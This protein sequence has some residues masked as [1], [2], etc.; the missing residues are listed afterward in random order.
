[1]LE[2]PNVSFSPVTLGGTVNTFDVLVP[3]HLPLDS[4]V[5]LEKKLPY[6]YKCIELHDRGAF[7]EDIRHGFEQLR[8]ATPALLRSTFDFSLHG[9]PDD[10]T[11]IFFTKI[12]VTNVPLRLLRKRVDIEAV[13]AASLLDEISSE[14]DTAILFSDY[15][16][17]FEDHF[18]SVFSDETAERARAAEKARKFLTEAGKKFRYARDPEEFASNLACANRFEARNVSTQFFITSLEALPRLLAS[19]KRAC[20]KGYR[21]RTFD[22]GGGS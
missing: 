11:S 15:G 22:A 19:L 1:L 7:D 20:L 18:R 17:D 2:D 16:P 13:R 8:Y 6:V 10:R 14:L 12:L 5:S 9:H 4:F 21:A 3:Y